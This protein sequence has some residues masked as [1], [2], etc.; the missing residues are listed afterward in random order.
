MPT[1]SNTKYQQMTEF[2]LDKQ[3]IKDL[4]IF[5]DNRSANS[6]SNF[7]DQTKTSGGSNFLYQLMKNPITD[8]N[9]Y[10]MKD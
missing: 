9:E 10:F 7:Y 2:D 1:V 3:T 5:V 8:I 4:E 6:I